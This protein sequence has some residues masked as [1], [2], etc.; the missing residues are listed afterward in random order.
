MRKEIDQPV[1]MLC[2]VWEIANDKR[3]WIDS[4]AGYNLILVLTALDGEG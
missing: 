1:L 4:G 2:V 3:R